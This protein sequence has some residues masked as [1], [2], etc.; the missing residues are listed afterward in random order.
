ML[1]L[2]K[3]GLLFLLIISLV[4]KKLELWL[5]LLIG[6][7]I[8]GLLFQV[9]IRDMGYT[10]IAA[11]SEFKTL[12]LIGAL[13][14]ILLFSNIM[15][16]T[17]ELKRMMES[18]KVILR[19]LRIVVAILPSIIG[20]MPLMGGAMISAPMVVKAS[21]ELN[22]S[23]E[24]RT[25]LNYW[26]RHIWEYV[27]PTYPGIVLTSAI[28]GVTIR[29]ISFVNLPLF[30]ASVMSGIIFGYIGVHK[31]QS[32]CELHKKKDIKREFYQLTKSLCPLIFVLFLVIALKVELVYSFAITV[33][34]LWLIYRIPLKSM[35]R[36]IQRSI[37]IEMGLM[38][39][40]VM[41]FQKM[42][43]ATK[44]VYVMSEGFSI[45]GFPH[46][47]ILISLPFIVGLLTGITI[48]FVG[49]TFPILL[50]IFQTEGHFLSYL[51]LAYAS[52][53]CGVILSP[54]HLC[55]ILT[56]D[57]FNAELNVVYRLLWLPAVSVL[58][59]GLGITIIRG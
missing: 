8:L 21:D 27:L 19:D 36:I 41:F 20:L 24:R 56:K 17:G 12:K 44:A 23:N 15:S 26:F 38:V 16:E 9:H 45:I 39:M 13:W 54:M 3:I 40:G 1:G 53:Y 59:V 34:M 47:I 42:L 2:L 6:S 43:E 5:I 50:P 10:F 48:A 35:K 33:S 28:L 51:M 55:L 32:N 46:F 18:F 25:F 30:L 22:L 58:F 37:S 4:L 57:Y 29:E 14:L 49:I 52:G 31:N 7:I 11:I